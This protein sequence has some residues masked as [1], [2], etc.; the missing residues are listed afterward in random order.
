MNIYLKAESNDD[1]TKIFE[2]SIGKNNYQ[3]SMKKYGNNLF[4]IEGN[5]KLEYKE[6]NVIKIKCKINNERNIQLFDITKEENGNKQKELPK[7]QEFIFKKK[8]RII[9]NNKQMNKIKY[10]TKVTNNSEM[11][12]PLK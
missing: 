6:K 10:T 12:K 1:I 8:C 9:S 11:E 4:K 7:N 3:F 2:N 5:Q